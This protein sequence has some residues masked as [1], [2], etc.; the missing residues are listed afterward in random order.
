MIC[1]EK[2]PES[3]IKTYR[4]FRMTELS[5]LLIA[6]SAKEEEML[7]QALLQHWPQAQIFTYSNSLS[8]QP[9]LVVVWKG[10]FK[11]VLPEILAHNNVITIFEAVEDPDRREAFQ[12]GLHELVLPTENR[13]AFLCMTCERLLERIQSQKEQKQKMGQS[14]KKQHRCYLFDHERSARGCQPAV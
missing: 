1:V 2:T 10:A 14:R 12:I 3:E 9:D 7:E 11:N 5:F 8:I 13:S 6:S 4:P